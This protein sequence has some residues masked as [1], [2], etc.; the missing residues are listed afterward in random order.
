MLEEL[1]A[2]GALQ[3]VLQL[4]DFDNHALLTISFC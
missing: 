4:I 2:H 1:G 3:V